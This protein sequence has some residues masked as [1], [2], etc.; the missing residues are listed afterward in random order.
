MIRVTVTVTV[1]RQTNRL[2]PSNLPLVEK[3]AQFYD[4][5]LFLSK[6]RG[7]VLLQETRLQ[8]FKRNAL[9]AGREDRYDTVVV[10]RV[11]GL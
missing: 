7:S 9:T 6:G 10:K 3:S 8:C 1:T 2:R 5:F 4:V 11:R